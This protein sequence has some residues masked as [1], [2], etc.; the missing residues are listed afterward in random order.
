MLIFGGSSHP[1]HES[2]LPFFE[3]QLP[4]NNGQSHTIKKFLESHLPIIIGNFNL[5]FHT[6]TIQAKPSRPVSSN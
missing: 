2:R 1:P 6:F 3:G 4:A 5:G